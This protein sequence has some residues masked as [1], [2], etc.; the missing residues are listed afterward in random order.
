MTEQVPVSITAHVVAAGIY[1]SQARFTV[2][3]TPIYDAN[4]TYDLVQ[5]PAA[6]DDFLKHAKLKIARL[7]ENASWRDAA[8]FTNAKSID[9]TRIVPA[10]WDVSAYWY[11]VMGRDPGFSALKLALDPMQTSKIS[12]PLTAVMRPSVETI[13]DSTPD[14]HGTARAKIVAELSAERARVIVNQLG[15]GPELTRP[16]ASA[17]LAMINRIEAWK[18]QRRVR[19]SK[20]SQPSPLALERD[21]AGLVDDD[22]AW[23]DLDASRRRADRF[24]SARKY[25]QDPNN[26]A[27]DAVKRLIDVQKHLGGRT[28]LD[29]ALYAGAQALGVETSEAKAAFQLASRVSTNPDDTIGIPPAMDAAEVEFARRRLFAIQTNPSLARL[30]GFVADFHCPVNDLVAAA[31]DNLG[32]GK[33]PAH[34]YEDGPILDYTADDQAIAR[35]TPLPEAAAQTSCFLLLNLESP[36]SSASM[37][38]AAKLRKPVNGQGHFFP[39]TREEI[40]ARAAGYPVEKFR[41]YAIAE[42]IDG[43]VDL[44]QTY[45][46][47]EADIEPRYDILTLDPITATAADANDTKVKETNADTIRNHGTQMPP[48]VKAAL[49]DKNPAQ[50]HRGGGLALADRWRQLHLI[51]RQMD[52]LQQKSD[53]KTKNIVLDASDLTVGY[54]LDV[55]VR[56]KD[57]EKDG[58]LKRNRWHTLMHRYVAYTPT[59]NVGTPPA[60]LNGYIDGFYPDGVARREADDGLL[61]VPAALR[62]WTDSQERTREH[63]SDQPRN[64]TTAFTEEVVGAWRGDPLGFACGKDSY[65]LDPS[66]LGIDFTYRLPKLSDAGNPLALTPP[67]LRFGWRYHFGLRAVYTGGISVPLSR[68][69]GHYEKD[70]GGELVL[71]PAK[72]EGRSYR[73]HERIDAPSIA[74]PDWMFGKLTRDTYYTRVALRG[75]FPAPQAGRMIVRTFNDA[76]NRQVAEIP[77]DPAE[78]QKMPGVGFDRRVILAPA[79][80]LEFA[81][82]HD[83]FRGKSEDYC[84]RDVPMYDPRILRKAQDGADNGPDTRPV[85]G[86]AVLPELTPVYDNPGGKDHKLIWGEVAVAW[87]GHTIKSRPRGGLRTID[88]RSAWGGFP[89]YRATLSAGAVPAIKNALVAP[90]P[91]AVTDEGEILHRIKGPGATFPGDKK[92]EILWTATGVRPGSLGQIERSGTAVFRPLPSGHDVKVEREPYYPDPAAV[93]VVVDVEIRGV[94]HSCSVD[95]YPEGQPQGAA[96]AGYP[97]ARPVVLDVVRS[98]GKQEILA[99]KPTIEYAALPYTPPGASSGAAI[100]ATHV[101]VRLAPGDDAKIRVWC[102]PSVN[103]LAFMFAA[104]ET[105]AAILLAKASAGA[106]IKSIADADKM[107]SAGL[108][109]FGIPSVAVPAAGPESANPPRLTGLGGLTL[110]SPPA[111]LQFAKD[112]RTYMLTKPLTEISA[113]TEIV[114]TH[115]VDLPL[116]DPRPVAGQSWKLLRAAS[117]EIDC[118]LKKSS[119]SPCRPD[120][121][122]WDSKNWTLENQMPDAVGV[123]IDGTLAIHGPTTGAVEIRAQGIAAA[124]G[125]FDDPNRGRT[126][127]DRGRGLW[128]KPD[129]QNYMSPKRLFGFTPAADGSVTFDR[130][131]VTVLRIEGFDPKVDVLNLLAF[132]RS[133]Y[134]LDTAT[135]DQP[136]LPLRAQRPSSFQDARA[137]YVEIF[138]VALSRHASSL[139]TRYD[140]LPEM[141]A[142]PAPL[143]ASPTNKSD[144]AKPLAALWLAATIR[145]PRIVPLP[146]IPSFKWTDSTPYPDNAKVP[147]VYVKRS[148]RVRLRLKRPWF[149]SGEG[150]RLGIVI[151]PPNLF[152]NDSN[153]IRND[154][155]RPLPADRDE[156]SLRTLPDDGSDIA[157]LQDV[158]LGPGG[159]WVTR[160]GADPIR[161][162]GAVQGWLLSKEN[163][164]CDKSPYN[165]DQPPSPVIPEAVL[166]ENVLMPVPIDADAQPLTAARPP[167]GFMLVS[168]ITYAPR[169]DSE[170]ENWYVDVE[171]NPCGSVYPFVRLGL[172]RYQP[173]APRN[174]QVSEPVVDWVQILPE[175]TVTACGK[176]QGGQ[177]VVTVTVEGSFSQPASP[178]PNQEVPPEQ[179][180][181]MHVTLLR[182]RAA[183]D[184]EAFGPE[185]PY[186]DPVVV[187]PHCGVGCMT[188]STSFSVDAPDYRAEQEHW[189]IFVE[190]MDRFRPATYA[191]EPRYETRKDSNFANTG[192]RFTARLPLDNLL[193]E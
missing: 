28:P 131:S 41:A 39:C 75:H 106:E 76:D 108:T 86:E 135:N 101:T 105:A 149:S 56:S 178:G 27:A 107:F 115:A 69:L 98:D 114:A 188:W 187:E 189:S 3:L 190:E 153:A 64:W 97:D 171:I 191:D 18:K 159:P 103:F 141:L 49:D 155:L 168:L 179:A 32:P 162:Q 52:S 13:G 109:A 167:G 92:P 88:Y 110:P 19:S 35:P 23:K 48:M 93:T 112:I 11:A 170:Q 46:S 54:K 61:Q 158:D 193:I 111:K 63:I 133:A 143:Q 78:Q 91:Q 14:I 89:V 117:E 151:W 5:W 122:L 79:V 58:Q 22:Q 44:G 102:V 177:T 84:Q 142:N 42:Q 1:G 12:D 53:F 4:G 77:A 87:R 6:V 47:P 130:E 120:D 185:Q 34:F 65:K 99:A 21:I 37:W 174:L 71:P 156:I 152:A 31:T 147:S 74:I 16:P 81:G 100:T 175:R 172:V 10:H 7:K 181:R 73:R 59:L 150:E 164:P 70:F 17:D 50:T 134:A 166:V 126:R 176:E 139:R 161:T 160:W 183:Q 124:R 148:M 169:F 119:V 96:P 90:T 60:N 82:L 192:P 80:S 45:R 138:A 113:V 121:P 182:R 104:T 9:A 2:A 38:S 136:D 68:A 127:D 43:I 154:R 146:P 140:E 20:L 40:D 180:P 85:P 129:S 72:K 67:P 94:S 26:S 25:Y 66:D 33:P 83:A 157:E 128:P 144:T 118:I 137:R 30:F 55:G 24:A 184:G 116:Q 125:I 123:L 51:S 8:V 29:A 145:P 95:L 62:Q 15:R 186:G 165:F 132:Q 36:K 57:D 163:F 173:H